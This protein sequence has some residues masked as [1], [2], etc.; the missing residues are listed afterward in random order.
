MQVILLERIRKLGQMGDV[1]KVKDGFARNYLLPLGKALRATDANLERFKNEKV[2]LETRNLELKGEAEKVAKKID[3]NIYLVIRQA[4]DAG[5]LFGSVATRDI[6]ETV[7]KGGA[8]V[9][10][11]QIMLL[12]PIKN[13]GLHPITISLHPEVDATVTINVARSDEEAKRQER[14][15]DILTGEL[16]EEEEAAIAAEEI[17]EDEELAQEAE[18]VLQEDASEAEAVADGES[19]EQSTDDASGD[20]SE[21]EDEASADEEAKD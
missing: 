10:R 4:S 9:E 11:R 1:V 5:Q 12:R 3:G 18:Q 13:L 21:G 7:S 20:A 16:D 6:A 8:S 15:E 17:F 14:G 19:A 2:Q